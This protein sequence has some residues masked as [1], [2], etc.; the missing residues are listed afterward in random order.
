[1]ELILYFIFLN[2]RSSITL[3]LPFL[4]GHMDVVCRGKGLPRAVNSG[5][6][7]H[8]GPSERRLHGSQAAGPQWLASLPVR[9]T[10]PLPKPA[11]SYHI[12]KSHPPEVQNLI[13]MKSRCGWSFL[14]TAPGV[15][16][17]WPK[18]LRSKKT[19][20]LLPHNTHGGTDGKTT[21]DTAVPKGW[22]Q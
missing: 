14:S 19:R 2:I 11:K 16:F 18:D 10:P 17:P 20:V 3:L 5:G 21:A 15:Q 9:N 7:K 13:Y 8:W 12:A 4:L 22:G 1:M 6:K